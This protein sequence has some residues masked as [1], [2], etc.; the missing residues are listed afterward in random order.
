RSARTR[1]LRRV[2]AVGARGE[3]RPTRGYHQEQDVHRPR[4][5]SRVAGRGRGDGMDALSLHDYTAAYALDA[6][7][8]EEA[9]RYEEHLATCEGTA[10]RD[11]AP[12]FI[13]L[14]RRGPR[15]AIVAVTLEPKPGGDAPQGKI[16]LH[17][18]TV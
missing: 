17:S 8:R 11:G 1:V 4:E 18:Q 13:P 7:D 2:H 3:A 5:A 15:G 12:L 9:A 10:P 16:V 6:L 14:D